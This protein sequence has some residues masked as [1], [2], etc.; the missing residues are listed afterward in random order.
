MKGYIYKIINKE[1]GNF[2][3][4]STIE[5]Q[6]R[7]K[8]HFGDLKKKKHHCLF[9]QRAYNKYGAN[10]FEF[11]PKEVKVNSEKELRLLEER[12]IGYCWN[13]GKLYNTSKKG[14]GGDLIS[15]HPNNKEFRK[16]KFGHEE[17]T[18][19]KGNFEFKNVKFGYNENLVLKDFSLKIDSGKTY[20]IV[21]K[22]GAGK[23]TIFNLLN[24][25]Y[26]IKSKSSRRK[27]PNFR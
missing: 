17:L 23:T 9:L 19:V 7:E 14:S 5:P 18:N 10:S 3:I 20:G 26:N 8:R 12:Y 2:Y 21:G 15:Y 11:L 24:K 1:N 16:E 25:L 22:S 13:S 27:C 6:K 4:G